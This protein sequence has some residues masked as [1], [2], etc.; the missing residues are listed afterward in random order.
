[1]MFNKSVDN[2]QFICKDEI[3]Q[4]LVKISGGDLRKSIMTLQTAFKFYG[5][6][7]TTDELLEIAGYVKESEIISTYTACCTQGSNEIIELAKNLTDDGYSTYQIMLQLLVYIID[8]AT[9]DII[10]AECSA[11]CGEVE[12]R[13]VEGGSEHI[14]LEYLL[15]KISSILQSNK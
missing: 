10:M 15:L 13:V 2:E 9:S 3:L 5:K 6:E 12:K 8:H 11:V 14:N 1:M 4:T 7:F